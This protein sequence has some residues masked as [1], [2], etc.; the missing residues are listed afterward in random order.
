M[1]VQVVSDPAG[2]TDAM[3][4][5][6]QFR[7]IAEMN[8][9]IVFSIDCVSGEPVYTSPSVETLLGYPLDD[10][11]LQ[12]AGGAGPL[13]P[14]CAGLAQRLQRFADGDTTRQKL[15]RAFD[16]PRAD[17]TLIPLEITSRLLLDSAGRAV[18]L[19]GMVRDMS[20]RRAR[21]SEQR[22]FASMLNHEFRTPLST[23][24]GAIQ[25]LEATHHHADE[26]TRARYRKIALAAD[27]LIAMLDDYLSPER[28]AE[29][30]RQRTDNSLSPKL[31]LEE[32]AVRA[33]E[34]GRHVR[35]VLG[36]LPARVRCDP[37]G[38]R[39]AVKI[40]VDNAIQFSPGDSTIVLRGTAVPA[41]PGGTF[42]QQLE[43]SVS[44][45]GAGIPPDEVALIFNKFFR[46]RN[47]RGLPGSGLGLYMARSVIEAH[48]GSVDLAS[49]PSKSIT[50]FRIALPIRD[51]GKQLASL[52][53][54]SDNLIVTP[55]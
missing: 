7:A 15:V 1:T 48:G 17:G 23:I 33:R 46:G 8:D 39:L 6:G 29:L 41:E 35:L 51:A 21:E 40:L 49:A 55:G 2:P 53:P 26:G 11:K 43:L 45:E 16:V 20:E 3:S 19:V 36:E 50:M 44:N 10:V 54:S 31:M 34:A 42:V 30:G 13:A 24:D 14:V 52:Q 38:L 37:A 9:D 22:R 32:G 28:M 18:V 5:E 47:A 12:A 25:R 27:R 4:P